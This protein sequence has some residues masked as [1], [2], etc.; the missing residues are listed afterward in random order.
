[1]TKQADGACLATTKG[2]RMPSTITDVPRR[3]G[4]CVPRESQEALAVRSPT[5]SDASGRDRPGPRCQALRRSGTRFGLRRRLRVDRCLH[6]CPSV[7]S[8]YDRTS[9]VGGN[10]RGRESGWGSDSKY[11][12][13]VARPGR[14]QARAASPSPMHRAGGGVRGPTHHATAPATCRLIER[15]P[16]TGSEPSLA[17]GVQQTPAKS[18][19]IVEPLTGQNY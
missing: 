2:L 8:T 10:L 9:Y 16:S 12:G 6:A 17:N 1:M 3:S 15:A 11:A 13:A 4:C 7:Q 5:D 19:K 14:L 18:D